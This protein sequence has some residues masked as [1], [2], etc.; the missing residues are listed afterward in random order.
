VPRIRVSLNA[1]EGTAVPPDFEPSMHQRLTRLSLLLV[2]P[3]PKME[4]DDVEAEDVDSEIAQETTDGPG[5]ATAR[6]IA[7]IH[8]LRPS[9][10]LT[11]RL[12]LPCGQCAN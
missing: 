9:N 5:S 8:V 7:T 3:R 10:L 4:T 11:S 12:E 6:P 1:D 2:E